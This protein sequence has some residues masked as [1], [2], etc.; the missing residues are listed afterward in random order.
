LTPRVIPD[1]T[2]RLRFR[3]ML[4]ADLDEM[5]AL[6]GDPEVMRYYPRPRTREEALGWIEWSRRSYA[7]H[8][9]GLWV[10][11][12]H[13]GDFVGDCGLTWQPVGGQQV[14]EVGYHVVPALQGR[15]YATEAARACVDLGLG[16]I[17]ESRVVAIIHPDNAPSRRVAVKVGLRLQEE[18]QVHGLRAVVYG[19]GPVG[20]P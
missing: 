17:G 9:H 11:E 20:R 10:V 1:P 19:R 18:T 15:G 13:D 16:A 8:G 3:E 14:L 6:L 5:A 2:E 7:E 12:T 4:E